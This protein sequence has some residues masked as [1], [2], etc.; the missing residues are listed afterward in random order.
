MLALNAAIEAMR[1]GEAGK[2]FAVVAEEVKA[3]SLYISTL[4]KN[5]HQ[6]IGQITSGVRHAFNTLN[7][8]ATTDMTPHLIAQER[9]EHLMEGVLQ[10]NQKISDILNDNAH[11]ST[12]ISDAISAMVM[13]MQFQDLNSQY[14]E[15]TLL[16]L[17][18]VQNGL[19]SLRHPPSSS[20]EA[21]AEQFLH[22]LK[23]G[24]FREALHRKLA[25]SGLEMQHLH[26]VVPSSPATAEEE[27]HIEFF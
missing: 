5:M 6:K 10:Q 22:C 9:L 25:E 8:V 23:L 17:Q 2:S 13:D 15:N 27:D 14:M 7:T 21:L 4:S 18:Q 19:H 11:H 20:T 26:P 1:A 16:L 3:V 24:E 12:E